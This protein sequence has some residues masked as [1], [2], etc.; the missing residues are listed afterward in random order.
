[1]K[2]F[3]K[4]ALRNVKRNINSTWLNGIGI[5]L[6]VIVLLLIFSL[7]RGIEN[8]IVSRTI[9]FETGAI[10][11][12]FEEK[13]SSYDNPF[14][15]SLFHV[16]TTA[17]DR[18][19]DISGY[20]YRIYPKKSILYQNENTQSVNVIGL[21]AKE[22]PQLAEMLK[23]LEGKAEY[24]DTKKGIIISNGIADEYS[25]K[26]GDECNIMAQS[27]DGSINL[28]DYSISGIFRYTSQM[29]KYNV[30]LAYDE[31]KSLYNAN[32]PS[33]IL[34][35]IHSFQNA[36]E[37]KS[38]LSEELGCKDNQNNHGKNSCKGFDI[39]SY[40]DHTGMA[41]TLSGINR[42]GMLSI[43]VF[44]ILISFVGIWSMQIENIDGRSKETGTLLSFGFSLPS[45]KKIF[46]LES[47]LSSFIYF[48][49]GMM[50]V[51]MIITNIHAQDGIFLGE[52]A[53]FAFGSS[54]INPIL[55]LKD[56]VLTFFIAL[57][58]PLTATFISLHILNKKNIIQLSQ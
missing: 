25:L 44:L 26:I 33:R 10:T 17:L 24:G 2:I 58:Y 49:I 38:T 35:N 8:Q 56:V 55:D 16:I 22:L 57:I 29:N 11:I 39:S 47:I 31:A 54:I 20:S 53:S 1:M 48:S 37:I 9:Q 18:S 19:T 13:T 27:V 23:L 34:I 30:Y 45:I 43:A 32:L 52:N 46:L 28:D 4:I 40:N 5:S 14:G 3:I 36:E 41:Q 42:Y 7:S 6:S 21:M 15:D 51:A 12:D 50:I